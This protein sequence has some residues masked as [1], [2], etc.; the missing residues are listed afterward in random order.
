MPEFAVFD[1]LEHK[2]DCGHYSPRVSP[3]ELVIEE[4]T[5]I[6]VLLL[7]E[8]ELFCIFPRTFVLNESQPFLQR[9]SSSLV[10]VEIVAVVS[11]N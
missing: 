10:G 4:F 11:I 2:F 3:F 9:G 8:S 5:D 1:I 6:A 7:S